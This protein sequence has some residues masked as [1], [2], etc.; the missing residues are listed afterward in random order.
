MKKN[1]TAS[2]LLAQKIAENFYHQLGY[3]TVERNFRCPPGEIDLLLR[4]GGELLVV[5]VKGR[6]QFNADEAWSPRWRAKKRHLRAALL[7]YLARE[8]EWLRETAF[9]IVY[10]TQGRVSERFTDEPLSG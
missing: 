1:T 4:R 2:G 10:V 3:S 9:E 8:P 6:A 5:E 7:W